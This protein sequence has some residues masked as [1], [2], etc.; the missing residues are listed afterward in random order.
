MK[1]TDHF[2][3]ALLEFLSAAEHP[4]NKNCGSVSDHEFELWERLISE[5]YSELIEAMQLRD[6]VGIADGI[7]DLLYVV[8]GFGAAL[9]MPTLE[10]F[11]E[12]Y[13]SNM[14]KVSG[15][16]QRKQ[17]GKI[18]KP[19]DFEQPNLGPILSRDDEVP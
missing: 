10:L 3:L 2:T 17:D 19:A 18:V 13:R 5:E 12:V 8:F 16:V 4:I 15:G 11:N 7:C 1:S 9:S 14:T 6:E